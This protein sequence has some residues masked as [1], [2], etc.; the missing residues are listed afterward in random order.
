MST[1]AATDDFA[2]TDERDGAKAG[3]SSVMDELDAILNDVQAVRG[4]IARC[5]SVLILLG[6]ANGWF[7]VM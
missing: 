3:H 1:L 4:W 5:L 7:G 6:G 2:A